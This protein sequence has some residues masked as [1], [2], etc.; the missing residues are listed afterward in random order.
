MRRRLKLPERNGYSMKLYDMRTSSSLG[1][2]GRMHKIF[3]M[4]AKPDVFAELVRKGSLDCYL[5][6]IHQQAQERISTIINQEIA[7]HGIT[8]ELKRRDPMEWGRQMNAI[9]LRAEEIVIHEIIAC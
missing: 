5:E 7:N 4:E 6:T 1:R 9:R 2:W 8:E 3:L